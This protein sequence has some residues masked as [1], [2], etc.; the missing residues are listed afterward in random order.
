MICV[1]LSSENLYSTARSFVVVTES[2][3]KFV[4]NVG[5]R[6]VIYW[7]RDPVVVRIKS[8]SLNW[9]C[10]PA[11]FVYFNDLFGSLREPSVAFGRHRLSADW[12]RVGYTVRYIYKPPPPPPPMWMWVGLSSDFS[13]GRVVVLIAQ[14]CGKFFDFSFHLGRSLCERIFTLVCLRACPLRK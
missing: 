3:R 5:V 6:L 13:R 14:L 8:I 7:T 1:F 9:F 4:I 10:L 11:E 12:N 2:P